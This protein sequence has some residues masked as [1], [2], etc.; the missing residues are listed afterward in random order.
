MHEV[1]RLENART[2]GVDGNH[3]LVG[4]RWGIGGDQRVARRA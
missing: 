3:D 1:G 4:S 2:A